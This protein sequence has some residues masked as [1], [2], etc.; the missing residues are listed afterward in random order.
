[1][2][3]KKLM[4]TL[5]IFIGVMLVAG[6]LYSRMGRQYQS[7]ELVT[8]TTEATTEA[9]PAATE[10]TERY[11]P[12]AVDFTVKDWDGNDVKLS[13]YFGKPIVLN[14]WAHWCGPCQ[15][16][17]PEF[18]ARYEELGGE[19]VFLMVHTDPDTAKGKELVQQNGYTFPVVFDESR[20]AAAYY[21]VT[22]FPTTY[23][24]DAD[25]KLQAYYVG[26]MTGDLLQTGIDMIYST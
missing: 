4:A 3:N 22:A 14:F 12:D 6:I 25:G 10:T 16:E 1:M 9:A 18:N 7:R 5:V 23:F 21:G 2:K 17:M 13:D 8:A 15:M 26:A 20:Q 24:I 19:V 11:V